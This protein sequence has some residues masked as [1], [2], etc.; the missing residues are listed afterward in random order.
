MCATLEAKEESDT[1][2]F[3][4]WKVLNKLNLHVTRKFGGYRLKLINLVNLNSLSAVKPAF[5]VAVPLVKTIERYSTRY[6]N[7]KF[8]ACQH[9]SHAMQEELY[10]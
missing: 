7:D 8:H 6:S 5:T 10:L 4:V 9:L 2:I 1:V 3:S